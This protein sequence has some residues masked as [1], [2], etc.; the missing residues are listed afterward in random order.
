[1]WRNDGWTRCGCGG[2]IEPYGGP[3]GWFGWGCGRDD[4]GPVFGLI[5]FIAE[6][7]EFVPK[8]RK[9]DY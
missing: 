9:V 3:C 8:T 1:M 2:G 5:R 4:K 7:G 6:C